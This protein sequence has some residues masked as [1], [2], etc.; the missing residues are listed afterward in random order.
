MKNLLF[1]SILTLLFLI[2]S[3]QSSEKKIE[4]SGSE[5]LEKYRLDGEKSMKLDTI[6]GG[7]IL[8]GKEIDFLKKELK[9]IKTNSDW[10]LEGHLLKTTL[11]MK[12]SFSPEIE[13]TI[14]PKTYNDTLYSLEILLSNK[15]FPSEPCM[16]TPSVLNMLT[17]KYKFD[18]MIFESEITNGKANVCEDVHCFRN[19]MEVLYRKGGYDFMTLEYNYLPLIKKAIAKEDSLKNL[20]EQKSKDKL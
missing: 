2:Y 18:T 6:F 9:L 7:F 10:Y 3:C 11:H 4:L 17:S 8:G 12:D 16:I 13:C 1:Y 15:K 5:K 19:N 20:E 14:F